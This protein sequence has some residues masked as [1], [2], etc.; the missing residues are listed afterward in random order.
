MAVDGV[1]DWRRVSLAPV[2]CGVLALAA[3]SLLYEP[4]RISLAPFAGASVGGVG[5]VGGLCGLFLA[6]PPCP[7][8][9]AYCFGGDVLLGF[10][11][12]ALGV[13]AAFVAPLLISA[14][15]ASTQKAER[16]RHAR[17]CTP[18]QLVAVLRA[19]R[20]ASALWFAVPLLAYARSPYYWQSPARVVL[21]LAIPAAFPLSWHLAF[22][23]VPA[24]PILT[25][26]V[27]CTRADALFVHKAVS[28]DA[29]RWAAVHASGE[30][31]Y[32]LIGLV[33]AHRSL[34]AALASLFDVF[35]DGERML[36]LCALGAVLV[37]SVHLAVASA[38]ARLERRVFRPLHRGL[39][40][41]LL[42][43]ATA[44]WWPLAILLVPAIAVHAASVEHAASQAVGADSGALPCPRACARALA[45][46]LS[47]AVSGLAAVWAARA[48]YMRANPA[49][50]HLVPFAFPPG[51]VCV[52]FGAARACVL[53]AARLASW[54]AAAGAGV[55]R[56]EGAE[57]QQRDE[58]AAGAGPSPDIATLRVDPDE[59]A[60]ARARALRQPLLVSSASEAADEDGGTAQAG[61]PTRPW[62]ANGAVST[63][64]AEAST[65][66]DD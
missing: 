26:L 55:D 34:R 20:C 32:A 61:R 33:T 64:L 56:G 47:G 13:L 23:A 10:T 63:L 22:V 46:A 42:L 48:A 41:L 49:D 44:H 28:R 24:A 8:N 35:G 27:P 2:A 19:W 53:T 40:A 14:L 39:A 12:F 43:L 16:A 3:V 45:A 21:I 30:A 18:A 17:G 62:S 4:V 38:R 50:D 59:E 31:A 9:A 6:R 29:A 54:R 57:H 25:A 36:Y 60:A 1:G 15:V 66:A 51:A 52:A 37:G 58:T 5:G 11:P 65:A 7:P